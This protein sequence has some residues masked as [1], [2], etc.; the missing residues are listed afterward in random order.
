M[1]EESLWKN[2]HNKRKEG[3]PPAKPGDDD[4]PDEK[5]WKAAQESEDNE[6][7]KVLEELLSFI[8]E[9]DK[10]R[11]KCNSPRYIKDGETGHGKKQKVVKACDPDSDKEKIIRFGDAKMRNNS[12][13]KKNKKNFRS[14]HNCEDKNMKKDWDTAGYWACKDW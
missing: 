9:Q 6:D 1:L 7:D 2:V 10:D 3:R 12:D 8:Q 5:A 4:Y 11:M 13:K 14:R